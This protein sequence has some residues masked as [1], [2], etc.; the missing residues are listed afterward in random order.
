MARPRRLN[1]TQLVE[2]GQTAIVGLDAS[3][4]IRAISPGMTALTGWRLN[5]LLAL[6]CHQAA[7]A[8]Q[9]MPGDNPLADLVASSLAPPAA[10]LNGHS[11]TRDTVLPNHKGESIRLQAVYVPL[12]DT[13]SEA[14]IASRA[15][16]Q[17]TASAALSVTTSAAGSSRPPESTATISGRHHRAPVT[18]LA[19]LLILLQVAP[20][21]LTH[22]S[23]VQGTL[24]SAAGHR[25]VSQQL[26]AEINALRLDLRKRF[27][28][29]SFIAEC[30]DMRRALRQ[31]ELLKS[32]QVPFCITGAAG[33]G[34]RHLMRLIHNGTIFAEQSLAFLD[35]HLL[36]SALLVSTLHQLRSAGQM[37]P[38]LAHHR[39]G[40]LVL[41]ELQ[42]LPIDVQRWM[43]EQH[44]FDAPDHETSAGSGLPVRISAT[45]RV[46]LDQLREQQLLLPELAAQ[47]ASVEIH[48]PPLHDR[49]EDVLLLFRQFIDE[50]RRDHKTRAEAFT[51]DVGI[52]LL[53][54]RWPG[55]VKELRTIAEAACK[56]CPNA[57]IDLPDL[58]Y[59]FRV[60][61]DAQRKTPVDQP[62]VVPLEQLLHDFETEVIAST[63]NSCNG[64]KTEAARRLGLTRPKFYRRLNTLGLDTGPEPGS[65]A[66]ST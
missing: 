10:C 23:L 24:P 26:H 51:D 64:N 47:L 48:L 56:N 38:M 46:P 31:A 44:Y 8:E 55:Q 29:E 22:S 30:P 3:L 61:Q 42:S 5:D 53:E 28:T 33:S 6:K 59:Q 52:H 65:P 25:S 39:T 36:S 58:P 43:L 13:L 11:V 20:P 45:S 66:E 14:P 9:P 54:Y 32:S 15:E 18:E 37:E 21:T 49:Y 7:Q 2:D 16:T 1:W 12:L 50:C 19:A 4:R 57:V 62:P 17:R 35:C 40:L 27:N 41:T 63:L 34:R 60:A